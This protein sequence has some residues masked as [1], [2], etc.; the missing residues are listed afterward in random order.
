MVDGKDRTAKTDG[1][2]AGRSFGRG[3]NGFRDAALG[4][5]RDRRNRSSVEIK[6]ECD[7]EHRLSR[8]AETPACAAAFCG[9]KSA[10]ARNGNGIMKHMTEEEVIAYREGVAEQRA[11]ISEHL[12]ACEDGVW[13]FERVQAGVGPPEC[14]PVRRA[15]AGY[16]RPGWR[17][18][19]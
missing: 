17:R 1:T 7:E 11:V 9:N 13:E 15:G 16:G 3:E 5:L 14:L 10:G 4:R 18:G 12:A 2:S 8:G 19:T 6:F